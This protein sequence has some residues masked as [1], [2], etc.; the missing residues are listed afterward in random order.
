MTSNR[1]AGQAYEQQAEQW[2]VEP[3]STAE[4]ILDNIDL[5]GGVVYDPCCGGGNLLDA[6]KGRGYRTFGTDIVNRGPAHQF[7]QADFLRLRDFPFRPPL[8]VPVS[9]LFNPPYGR[10]GDVENMAE[11]FVSHA[12]KHFADRCF[13]MVALVPIEF[14]CGQ[15]RYWQIYRDNKPSHEL[16]CS[17]RPSMPPGHLVAQMGEKAHKGGKSDFCALV[18]TGANSEKCEVVWMRPDNSAGKL[19]SERRTK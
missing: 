3:R 2:Y 19:D 18:W 11:K 10:V 15:S 9:L 5:G 7:R 16:K 1:R 8:D 17:Q 13:R 4:Q 12:L 6:A 14:T